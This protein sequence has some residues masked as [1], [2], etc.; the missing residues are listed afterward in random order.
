MARSLNPADTLQR[1]CAGGVIPLVPTLEVD[2][3]RRLADALRSGG[4]AVAEVTLR[5]PGA[6]D[7]LR[8]LAGD[9]ELL[10]GA[11]TVLRPQQVDEARDA[12]ARF[13]VTPGVSQAVLERCA[14]LDMPVLPGVATATEI[15]TAL[16]HGLALLKLFPAQACGGVATL[17]ALAGPFP[18]VR[19]VPTGGVNAGNAA[20]YLRLPTVTAVGGSWMTAP[21]L[22]GDF[23]AVSRLAAEAVRIAVEVRG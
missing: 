2:H 20:S 17:T 23:A 8:V 4:L 19:F 9:G 5:A 1:A 18:D 3:A 7:V 6:M 22:E 21:A 14:E 11:G 12:G 15:I 13:I 16:D 10:V